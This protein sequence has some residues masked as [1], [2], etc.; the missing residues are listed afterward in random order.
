MNK[1]SYCPA[2][3]RINFIDFFLQCVN[4]VSYLISSVLKINTTPQHFPH[5]F[6]HSFRNSI[7]PLVYLLL[8]LIFY[9]LR[10]ACVC[11]NC[12]RRRRILT[13]CWKLWFHLISIVSHISLSL[14]FSF[15]S[16]FY[17]RIRFGY[18]S[19]DG[20]RHSMALI[21]CCLAL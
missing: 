8:N 4:S 10:C 2:C 11:I 5:S 14:S 15:C 17:H 18:F 16:W 9:L 6:T 19:H 1:I 21:G 3:N 13:L 20:F 7:L 12:C